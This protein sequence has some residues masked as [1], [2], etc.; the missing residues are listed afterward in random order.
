MVLSYI[1]RFKKQQNKIRHP[2]RSTLDCEGTLPI[3]FCVALPFLVVVFCFGFFIFVLRIHRKK[4]KMLKTGKN[5]I[6]ICEQQSSFLI[7]FTF[8]PWNLKVFDEW[9]TNFTFKLNEYHKFISFFTWFPIN[10]WIEYDDFELM[11][12]HENI[13]QGFCHFCLPEQ[14]SFFQ[15]IFPASVCL[16]VSCTLFTYLDFF[17]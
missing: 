3:N 9:I 10:S 1:G 6:F 17:T 11:I 5:N 7:M 16:S 14:I 4:I 2:D 8:F 12:Y 15:F 13:D